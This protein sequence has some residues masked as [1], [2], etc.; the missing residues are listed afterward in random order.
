MNKMRPLFACCMMIFFLSSCIRY[1][2]YQSPLQANTQAYK[3]IPLHQ[4]GVAAATYASGAFTGGGANDQLRDGLW[5]FLGGLH[6]SHNFGH[7]QAYYG[8]T[9]SLGTY[10]VK[11]IAQNPEPSSYNNRNLNDSLIRQMAGNKFFGT[12]GANAGIN[13]VLPFENGGE[14]RVVGGEVSWNN[15][16]GDYL[17]FRQKLPDTAA[18]L[19]DRNR[20][21]LT[22]SLST[23][24]IFPV[25]NGSIGFKFSFSGTPRTINGHNRDRSPTTY[26]PAYFSQ[27][28]HVTKKNVTGYLQWNLGTK[29]AN[30]QF[31]ANVRLGNY[32]K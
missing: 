26:S 7:F 9:G 28:I 29:A 2:Y 25:N 17:R 10:H 20:Q 19:I 32:R 1:A 6:R 31:G 5:A 3:A 13:V 23:D 21:Y 11:A 12:W 8:L 27:T 18:N 14:W 15:E 24:V 22:L 4:E 16:F 30:M